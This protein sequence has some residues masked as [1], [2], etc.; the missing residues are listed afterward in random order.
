MINTTISHQ[1]LS[2]SQPLT[3]FNIP[4]QQVPVKQVYAPA[5]LVVTRDLNFPLPTT[6]AFND[7]GAIANNAAL[8]PAQLPRPL[9][10][11]NV[12]QTPIVTPGGTT[13]AAQT[14][15]RQHPFFRTE[16]LQKIMNLTTVRTQQFAVYVTVGFFEVKKEGNSITLQPDILG[17]EIDSNNRFTMFA[18]I[19]RTKADGFNPFHPGNYRDLVDYSRR[20]K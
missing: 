19:D 4:D 18:V 14:D 3:L 9:L 6:T 12:Y 13:Y 15:R 7:M 11:A 8:D 5:S 16:L 2:T 20:L 10:G 17:A 1:N